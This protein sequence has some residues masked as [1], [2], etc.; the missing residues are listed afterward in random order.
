[1]IP[2]NKCCQPMG[3]PDPLSPLALTPL[4]AEREGF[5]EWFTLGLSVQL[6]F[7][8]CIQVCV[9]I[10]H[11]QSIL[12][13]SPRGLGCTNKSGEAP[14]GYK[15]QAPEALGLLLLHIRQPCFTA[16]KSVDENTFNPL[17]SI[18]FPANNPWHMGVCNSHLHLRGKAAAR[19]YSGVV[20]VFLLVFCYVPWIAFMLVML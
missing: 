16:L 19:G 11:T 10:T 5:M 3:C 1:M 14:R 12:P 6:W 8:L 9:Y 18:I 7:W 2:R 13:L 20:K 17:A 4:G 15:S